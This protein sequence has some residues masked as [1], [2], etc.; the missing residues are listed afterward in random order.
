MFRRTSGALGVMI[1]TFGLAL[2]SACKPTYPRCNKDENC[3]EKGEVCVN[4]QCQECRDE[5]QCDLRYPNE[6][7]ACVDG[8]CEAKLECH[9]D[10]DCHSVGV[11]LVCRNN[12]CVPECM[13]DA[14]C[15]SGRRCNA[16]KCVAECAQDADCGPEHT[17]QSGSC[18]AAA[19]LGEVPPQCQ[20]QGGAPGE[21]VHLEMVHFDFNQYDLTADAREALSQA[22]ACLKV[23]PATLHI[24]AEGHCDDR[25][26]QEYNLALGERRAQAVF[27]YLKTLGLDNDRLTM[28]SKGENEPLCNEPTEACYA[29]NRRVQF[30]QVVGAH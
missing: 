21:L 22:V 23:A 6:K 7:R 9:L 25:G 11:D 13:Q 30:I 24:V 27:K 14:D 17:C 29:Q 4:G 19:Q 15:G 8:R 18:I 26:T 20:P 28:R 5:S 3:H 2:T 10:A 12:H 16:Q 1:L